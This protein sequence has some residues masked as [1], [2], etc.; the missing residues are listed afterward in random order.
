MEAHANSEAAQTAL[1]HRVLELE[2]QNEHLRRRTRT[3][4]P[5]NASQRKRKRDAIEAVPTR[6]AG[7][8]EH[9]RMAQS[10]TLAS[11]IEEKKSYIIEEI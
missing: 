5:E 2:V 11:K 1:W 10:S 6:L 9:A 3:S 8:Q 4:T 7:A